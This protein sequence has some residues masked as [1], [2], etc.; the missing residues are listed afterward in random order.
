MCVW[1]SE[2]ARGDPRR[3]VTGTVPQTCRLDGADDNA[4]LAARE[5]AQADALSRFGN[6]LCLALSAGSEFGCN[7]KRVN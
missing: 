3:A 2:V 4:T 7:V 1:R 5:M 6:G